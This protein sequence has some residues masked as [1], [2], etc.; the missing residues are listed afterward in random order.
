MQP[1][2]AFII[3]ALIVGG[4]FY[5]G[6]L[7]KQEEIPEVQETTSQVE[8]NILP[9]A[10]TFLGAVGSAL[11]S[12][13]KPTSEPAPE[14]E[15]ESAPEPAEEA[16][17]AEPAISVNTYI[18]SGPEKGEVIDGTNKVT[19]E[20][21]AK[22]SPEETEGKIT[23]ETK[24]KELDE[25][26]KE[27]SS[28]KRTINLPAGPEE[29]TFLVRA[30]IK[31]VIDPTPAKRTFKINT[32]SYFGKVTISNARAESSSRSSS[33]T[34]TV[35]LEEGEKIN[36]TGW[37]IRGRKG[38]FTIP[39]GIEKYTPYYNPIPDEDIVIDRSGK[40]YLSGDSNPLGNGRNF[41][42]NKC[43]GYLTNYRDFPIAISKNCPKPEK[44]EL[45][46]LE[47]CCQKFILDLGRCEMPEYW[48]N[49]RISDDSE[50]VTYINENLNYAGCYRKYSKDE[51]FLG[52]DWHI[53]MNKNFVVSDDCDTLYLRDQNGLIVDIY[54]YGR[55][56][57]R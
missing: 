25:D 53:Y 20:F 42:S 15:T 5:F 12:A 21:K 1:I 10:Q 28:Q 30:K 57:C 37:E 14:P 34:L 35:S 11:E 55:L 2:A 23:F 17:E 16:P 49:S 50:C 32:S 39:S 51:D 29:Y 46:Y 56:I 18:I 26:W 54:D 22:V 9:K 31:D 6:Q 33:I 43:L 4:F 3:L 13:K 45:S 27:T 19:F 48:E 8:E 41:R 7:P 52:D 24:I 44:E 40:I 36:I 47:P 38:G